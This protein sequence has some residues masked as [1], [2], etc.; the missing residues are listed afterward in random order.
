MSRFGAEHFFTVEGPL[1]LP[2][3]V[4]LSKAEISKIPKGKRTWGGKED[5]G[6]QGT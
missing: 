4:M 6:V 3:I 1:F 5:F 2:L